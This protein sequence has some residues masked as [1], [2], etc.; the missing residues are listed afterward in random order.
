MSETY[1]EFRDLAEEI[2][3]EEG[4]P[5]AFYTPQGYVIHGFAT[6]GFGYQS[7]DIDGTHV[8]QGD[9]YLF[10]HGAEIPTTAMLHRLNNRTYNAV[11]IMPLTSRDG[12]T[13]LCKVQLRG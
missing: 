11:D 7:K 1:Q 12:V 2:I 5:A 8:Q 6:G 4:S 13:A 3:K 9:L 10:W